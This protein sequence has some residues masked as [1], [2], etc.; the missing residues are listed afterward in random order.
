MLREAAQ[1]PPTPS[2]LYTCPFAVGLGHFLANTGV[3]FSCPE[4]QYGHETLINGLYLANVMQAE[5]L[6][7]HV[8]RDLLS[9]T[10]EK[11]VTTWTSACWPPGG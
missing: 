1:W 10:P 4:S 7:A 2:T 9:L 8:R 5:T 11:P 3:Y 6:K